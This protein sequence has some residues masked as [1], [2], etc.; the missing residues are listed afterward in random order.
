M[1]KNMTKG[2]AQLRLIERTK[3]ALIEAGGVPN[4]VEGILYE[5]N[6]ETRIGPLNIS[7]WPDSMEY[8]KDP[9]ISIMTRFADPQRARKAGIDCNSH[10]GKWNFHA[11]KAIDLK[12]TINLITKP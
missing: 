6:L 2:A 9:T 1:H 3:N 10:N 5:I 7:I 8:G 11:I 4:N 12:D